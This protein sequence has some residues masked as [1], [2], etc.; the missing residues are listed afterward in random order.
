VK[1]HCSNKFA[2]LFHFLSVDWDC[3]NCHLLTRS[4]ACCLNMKLVCTIVQIYTADFLLFFCQQMKYFQKKKCGILLKILGFSKVTWT[5]VH[6]HWSSQRPKKTWPLLYVDT[7][8]L[9]LWSCI[10]LCS[11]WWKEQTC[12]VTLLGLVEWRNIIF[13]SDVVQSLAWCMSWLLLYTWYMTQRDTDRLLVFSWAVLYVLFTV[14][15][16]EISTLIW[17]GILSRQSRTTGEPSCLFR[18]MKLCS[19]NIRLPCVEHWYTLDEK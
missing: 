3:W 1:L 2:S 18:S 4:L 16:C 13:V 15:S 10:S 14:T 7:G 17:R 12:I 11:C 5:K 8:L 19:N 6:T 9:W